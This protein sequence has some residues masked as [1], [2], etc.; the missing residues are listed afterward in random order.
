MGLFNNC[1]DSFSKNIA[2]AWSQ[3]AFPRSSPVWCHATEFAQSCGRFVQKS[4]RKFSNNGHYHRQH[5][6]GGK[7]WPFS[8]V[9]VGVEGDGDG[10]V[11]FR[12]RDPSIRFP[13]IIF[14]AFIT[15]SDAFAFFYDR[16]DDE[17]Q[18]V[19]RTVII[20]PVAPAPNYT[21][22]TATKSPIRG[23]LY[24]QGFSA[25]KKRHNTGVPISRWP[26]KALSC[27]RSFYVY[28]KSAFYTAQY[29]VILYCLRS[30][31]A[32][33]ERRSCFVFFFFLYYTFKTFG[34]N[35]FFAIFYLSAQS[36]I[37]FRSLNTIWKKNQVFSY[38]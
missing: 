12:W 6:W 2:E 33:F 32:S 34:H 13:K 31:S 18:P 3:V 29:G 25:G 19:R 15:R 20:Q 27:F 30:C 28:D 16:I 38:L 7:R 10:A 21:R 26:Q 23:R 24:E 35:P 17:V 4:N 22:Q 11:P 36:L 1:C 9:R 8:R 37:M 14:M 5:R